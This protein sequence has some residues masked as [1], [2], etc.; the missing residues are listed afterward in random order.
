MRRTWLGR[1]CVRTP[2]DNY[3]PAYSLDHK[4]HSA[5]RFGGPKCEG[6]VLRTYCCG[7]FNLYI[8]YSLVGFAH[9]SDVTASLRVPSQKRLGLLHKLALRFPCSLC[10]SYLAFKTSPRS[11]CSD[12]RG[13]KF[14]GGKKF[15]SS[16]SNLHF[17]ASDDVAQL[18][19]GRCTSH[20]SNCKC[21]VKIT[22]R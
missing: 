16:C 1:S 19:H 3:G 14:S 22:R 9:W 4:R 2:I 5:H 13:G 10:R 7:A 21:T 20:L 17:R 15:L 18:E 6:T 8:R 12:F 11:C